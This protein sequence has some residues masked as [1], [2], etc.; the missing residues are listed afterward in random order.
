[1]LANNLHQEIF[2]AKQEHCEKS[3]LG[4]LI[5]SPH[6]TTKVCSVLR[7][8]DFQS[9]THKKIFS[10]II[11]FQSKI[12]RGNELI[13]LDNAIEETYGEA[14][15]RDI[16][17]FGYLSDLCNGDKYYLPDYDILNTAERIAER[18][19]KN[20][21]KRSLARC[22]EGDIS[23]DELIELLLSTSSKEKTNNLSF[24][25]G[26]TGYELESSFLIDDYLPTKSFGVIYGASGSYKSFHAID[27]GCSIATGKQW[28]GKDT[29]RGLVVYIAGEGS[30]GAKKRVRA[31]EIANK[32]DATDFV[33]IEQAVSLDTQ[34]GRAKL[35]STLNQIE[36]LVDQSISLIIIDTLAR[37]IAGD[38]NSA[39]D[40]GA[41]IASCDTI[42]E[43]FS[44]TVLVVHHSGKDDSKGAR[45][46]SSLKAACDFEFKIT[47]KDVQIYELDCTKAKDS[48]A[49]PRQDFK[50]SSF[51]VHTD[52]KGRE[53]TSLSR[54]GKGDKAAPKRTYSIQGDTQIEKDVRTILGIL[55]DEGGTMVHEQL[56]DTFKKKLP[57]SVSDSS[58]R[59][60]QRKA[61]NLAAE[62]RLITYDAKNE[63]MYYSIEELA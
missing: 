21:E 54:T 48:E 35:T 24:S 16:G 47:K 51:K 46:S 37:S 61:L 42:K 23:T 36:S 53:I 20:E 41:F 27:W 59:A 31:W 7:S 30:R 14:A 58:R 18:A 15:T 55:E 4:A 33:I 8:L 52:K 60:R 44:S 56:R 19:R 63:S 62:K 6:H 22:L 28:N 3:L 1:M 57:A 25:R 45:G 2:S 38:E 29:D 40:M 9:T 17:G 49:P 26:S 5:K 32:E 10:F 50:L 43:K 39:K 11:E 12:E 13:S 34:E